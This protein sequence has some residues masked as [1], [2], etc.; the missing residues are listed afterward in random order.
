MFRT[1]LL[2]SIIIVSLDIILLALS[3]KF[4]DYFFILSLLFIVI[5]MFPVFYYFEKRN[6]KA[7]EMILIAVLSALGAVSRIPFTALPGVQPTS[8]IIMMTGVTFGGEIGFLVGSLSALASNL[9]LGQG[10][11]TPWQMFAWSMMGLSSS[12]W[13][14]HSF[15]KPPL[16]FKLFGLAWG[17]LFGWIM[18]IWAVFSFFGDITPSL[19]GT[20]IISSFYFDLSHGIANVFFI[21]LF[22]SSWLSI[23]GRVKIKYGLLDK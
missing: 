13:H 19:L 14:I 23:L 3:L 9:I 21:S 20:S 15:S 4:T 10:P 22:T 2:M 12:L 6:V 16:I 8:F 5:S 11:W 17:F 1:K 7:E 18:N